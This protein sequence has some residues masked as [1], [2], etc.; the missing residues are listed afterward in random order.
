MQQAQQQ[1]RVIVRPLLVDFPTAAEVLS[2][3]V[4]TLQLMIREGQ[5][6][7]PRQISKGRVGYLVRDLEEFAES[8]PESTIAPPPNTG[9]K[10]P[11]KSQAAASASR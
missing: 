9:A 3:S 5:I 6:K 11:R 8:R 10:K 7:P 4:S 2:V 1:P